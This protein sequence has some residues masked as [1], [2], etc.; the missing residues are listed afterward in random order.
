M[1]MFEHKYVTVFCPYIQISSSEQSSSYHE[2]QKL[3][4]NNGFDS[5]QTEILGV[6][7]SGHI[8]FPPNPPDVSLC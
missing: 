8:N 1:T 3:Q 2:V 4:V 6:N 5:K 7:A